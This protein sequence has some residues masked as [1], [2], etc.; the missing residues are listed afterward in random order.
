[1]SSLCS[2]SIVVG[3]G[4]LALALV[5]APRAQSEPPGHGHPVKVFILAGQSNAVGYNDVREYRH[6]K[7]PFPAELANQP[8]IL[9]WDARKTAW[10]PLRLGASQ[11]SG[12]NAFGPELGFARGIAERL[13]GTRIALVKVAVGSTGLARSADYNDYIPTLNGFNDHGRNWHPSDD[14]RPA[15]QLYAQLI[16]EVERATAALRHDGVAYELAAVL[17]MQGEH[18]AGIS[19]R[20]A[21]DYGRLLSGL[22]RSLRAD[23]RTPALPFAVGEVSGTW[24]YGDV[25]RTAQADVC[26]PDGHAALV[27]TAD[28]SRQGSGGTAHYDADGMVEL[29]ARFAVTVGSMLPTNGPPLL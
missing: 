23:L 8:D 5:S 2:V 25:V 20:M 13:P 28:L 19:A 11:G 1:M 9:F 29:G 26:G 24:P 22:M 4:C 17:W 14:G 7:E 3:A 16:A 6:G 21:G 18:E 12:T 10:I 15:G 27:R